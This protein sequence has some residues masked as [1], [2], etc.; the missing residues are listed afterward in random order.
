MVSRFDTQGYLTPGPASGDDHGFPDH[1]LDGRGGLLRHARRVAASQ[2]LGLPALPPWR[3]DDDPPLSS[4]PGPGLPVRSL[5]PGLQRLHRHASTRHPAPAQRTGPDRPWDRPRGP[6]RPT[7]PRAG[8]R[9][10]GTLEPETSP[11]RPGL[12]PSGPDAAGGQG[13]GGRR[14]IPEC[15]GEK[16]CRIP[17]PTTRRDAGRTRRSAMVVGTTTARRSAEWWDVTAARSG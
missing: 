14:G 17:I 16:A 15:G 5:W 7:G 11:A 6:D 13:R 8:L 1:R 12:P 2:R 9:P 3:P 10:L 4:R